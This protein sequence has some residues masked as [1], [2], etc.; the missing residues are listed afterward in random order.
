MTRLFQPVALGA[1]LAMLSS[2]DLATAQAKQQCSAAMPS[3]PHGRWWSYRL[4]DGRKCWYEG[5]PNLSKSLLEWPEE[6]P[7]PPA[8]REEAAS[9]F[10]RK[11]GNLLNAQALAQEGVDTFEARWSARVRFMEST[12]PASRPPTQGTLGGALAG[13][14]R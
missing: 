9:A 11:P 6:T 10:A 14:A 1:C 2:I 13:A 3:D 4:I 5:K 12:P 7:A 8:P